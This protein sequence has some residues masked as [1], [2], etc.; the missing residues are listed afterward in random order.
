VL[1]VVQQLF[2]TIFTRATSCFHRVSLAFS[3][4]ERLFFDRKLEVIPQHLLL[5]FFSLK[6]P[7][8]SHPE[9]ETHPS[10]CGPVANFTL[11]S[12]ATT[13]RTTESEFDRAKAPDAAAAREP[14]I[15]ERRAKLEMWPDA[16]PTG[17]SLRKP[18]KRKGAAYRHKNTE[19]RQT[20]L[21]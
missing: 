9:P 2:S 21:H 12:L 5:R 6:A 4:G 19:P 1:H 20:N 14:H 16:N 15:N 7:G 3:T 17:R 11:R 8:E 18:N 10:G 13:A